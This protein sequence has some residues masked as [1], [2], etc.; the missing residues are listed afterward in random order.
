VDRNRA[1]ELMMVL[2]HFLEPIRKPTSEVNSSEHTRASG[3]KNAPCSTMA[4]RSQAPLRDQ[5]L[6]R[7][8]SAHGLPMQHRSIAM[9]MR[10]PGHGGRKAYDELPRNVLA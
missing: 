6:V 9:S 7:I 1:S 8:S 2:R 5:N 3:P 10:E 4:A